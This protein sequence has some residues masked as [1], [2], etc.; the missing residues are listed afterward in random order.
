MEYKIL[1]SV[2]ESKWFEEQELNMWQME[3]KMFHELFDSE[4]AAWEPQNE[5]DE[6]FIQYYE[7]VNLGYLTIK[8]VYDD[9]HAFGVI[10]EV[11]RILEH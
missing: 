4:K 7:D 8:R 3:M 10:K 5:E 11:V 9:D 6:Q 1:R 2:N